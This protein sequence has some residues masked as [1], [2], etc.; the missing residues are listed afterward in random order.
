MMLR[1]GVAWS[2]HETGFRVGTTQMVLKSDPFAI[3]QSAFSPAG[4]AEMSDSVR[5][6]AERGVQTAREGYQR[7]RDATE[8]NQDALE[9]VYQS[10]ARGAGD[11]T[12]KL[13]DIARANVT[14][15]FDFVEALLG[16]TSVVDAVEVTNAHA[17]KQFELLAAQSQ[18]LLALGQKV[19]TDAVEPMKA[20]AVRTLK[21][22]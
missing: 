1:T 18:D 21:P 22:I 16:S 6:F 9:A 17:R 11:Y 19:A 8:S 10:A 5:A 12:A 20:S 3:S 7:L 13:L 2:G 14:G 15:T 4:L